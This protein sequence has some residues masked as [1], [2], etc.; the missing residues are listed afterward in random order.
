MPA[1]TYTAPPWVLLAQAHADRAEIDLAQ[2]AVARDIANAA[3]DDV[4][5]PR[6]QTHRKENPNG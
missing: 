3:Y 5:G 2:R 1:P 6:P 4:I